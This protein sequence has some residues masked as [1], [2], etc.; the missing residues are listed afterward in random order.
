M[1]EME[2]AKAVGSLRFWVLR[3]EEEVWDGLLEVG[4]EAVEEAEE[5][6]ES[7][8]SESVAEVAV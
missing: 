2:V 5:W 8:G 1:A 7:S 6:S 4:F 3:E